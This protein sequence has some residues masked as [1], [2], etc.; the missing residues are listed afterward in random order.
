MD[1]DALFSNHTVVEIRAVE[2]KTRLV[3][4]ISAHKWLKN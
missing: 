4:T 1:S 3:L 2:N